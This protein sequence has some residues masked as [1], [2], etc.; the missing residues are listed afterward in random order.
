[1]ILGLT[2]VRGLGCSVSVRTG[3]YDHDVVLI[4]VEVVWI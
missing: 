1:M 4:N 3:L 2:L